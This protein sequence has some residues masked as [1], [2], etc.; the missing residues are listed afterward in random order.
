MFNVYMFPSVFEVF[1]THTLTFEVANQTT[2]YRIWVGGLHEP[3]WTLI[4]CE[5]MEDETEEKAK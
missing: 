4:S 3:F 1:R 5:A 2:P